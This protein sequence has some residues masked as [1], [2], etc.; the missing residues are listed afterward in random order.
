MTIL[1]SSETSSE[2]AFISATIEVVLYLAEKG[3]SPSDIAK[4]LD[5]DIKMVEEI[6]HAKSKRK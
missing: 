4:S 1:T 6:I 5:L 2:G 3:I